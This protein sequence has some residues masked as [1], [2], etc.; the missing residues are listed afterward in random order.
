MA[1]TQK[2][3]ELKYE[4]VVPVAS[5]DKLTAVTSS[6]Y[7]LDHFGHEFNIRTP[8]GNEAH[9]ACVGFGLER[10]TLALLKKHGFDP[11]KWPTE[12]KNVLEM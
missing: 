4:L 11:D 1:A 2:E 6:N 8:D 7:H 10:I 9:T 12:V 5:P 3:Q